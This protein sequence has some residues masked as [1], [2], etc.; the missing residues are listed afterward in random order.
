[1][2]C[3]RAWPRVAVGTGC[4]LVVEPLVADP[5]G[6]TRPDEFPFVVVG[7]KCDV[8]KDRVTVTE[9]KARAQCEVSG[10]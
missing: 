5:A 9:A 3:L 2:S 6:L 8:E 7:N 1:M 10:V 4:D